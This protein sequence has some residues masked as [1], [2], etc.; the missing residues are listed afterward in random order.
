[1]AFDLSKDIVMRGDTPEPAFVTL[2]EKAGIGLIKD[3]EIQSLD[4]PEQRGGLW[5][6]IRRPPSVAGRGDETASASREPWVD[7][8]GY[9]VGYL[10]ALY[11]DK[12]AV[13]RYLPDKLGDRAVPFDSLE[14]A[15][16]EAWTAGGNYV[17][18]MEPNYREALL[19]N[20]AKAAAAWQQLG[21]TGRWLREN[22]ALFRQPTVPIVTALVDAGAPSAEIANLLYRRNASPALSPVSAVPPPGSGHRLAIVAVNLKAPPPD[23]MKRL[24]AHAEAGATVVVTTAPSGLTQVR[25]DNDRVFYSLGKGQVVAYKRMIADPSEFALDVIDLVTH[26]RRAVRLWNAPSV[27]A[28]A[29]ASPRPRERLVHLVNYGSPIDSDVQTR[30]QGHYAKAMLLRPDAEPLTLQAAKR[31]TMTEV[32]VPELKRL[33]VVVFS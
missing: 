16:I 8:N 15:L 10:R 31:G 24:F 7:A 21:R 22:I 19:R 13:L 3:T 33:G 32:Q 4:L 12:P 1:M 9:Q 20:D 17:L 11:P 26:K 23:L 25:T 27:I 28:L 5:P 29:T 30:V 6:G 2:C 14:L 18:A